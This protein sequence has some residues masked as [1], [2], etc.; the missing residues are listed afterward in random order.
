[1]FEVVDYD[2]PGKFEMIGQVETTVG[3]IMGKGSQPWTGELTH[4]G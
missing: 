2:S 1:M 3:T 4:N